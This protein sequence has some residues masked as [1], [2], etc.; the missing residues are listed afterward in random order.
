MSNKVSFTIRR[1]TPVSRDA[2]SGPESDSSGF[3]VPAIPRHL[4]QDSAPGSPLSRSRTSSPPA[5]PHDPDSS[6]DEG[7]GMQ[8]EL[9]TSFD[10]LNGAQRCVYSTSLPQGPLVIPAL[11]NRDW[12]EMARKRRSASQFVPDSAKA[13]TG[14]DGSVGGLGTR[15]TINSGPVL[16]GLQMR[17]KARDE[18]AEVDD[19]EV[20]MVDVKAQENE[21]EETEDQKALRA[22]LAAA[23][24][25][26]GEAPVIDVIKPV[27]ETD[28]FKQDVDELPDAAS[29]ED[30]DRVPVA[31][32]GLALLRG[33]GWKEGT[34]A[35]RKP[36][37]GLV[38]PYLPEARPALLGIGAKEQEVYDDGS[39]NKKSKRPERRYVPVIK[40]DKEANGSGR[41][42]NGSTT[43]S[44]RNSRSRSPSRRDDDRKRDSS[45]RDDYDDRK[46]ESGRRDDRDSSRR[47]DDRRRD[48][49][50][51]DRRREDRYDDRR[52][53][54]DKRDSDRYSSSS[55]R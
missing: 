26:V 45:R 40:Q 15:D 5:T 17:E 16:S 52:R 2:S 6:D 28:A 33:M 39:K 48:R 55:R 23:E 47:D 1:P 42:E 49:S 54:Y 14:K 20:E 32:F 4:T 9:V 19:Q 21:E 31:Q 8:D 34:A 50:Y 29:L 3:K 46:R 51:D 13:S 53:D 22:I 35:S 24:G 18:G 41:S 43:V 38:Q 11:K 10:A 7:D 36:G 37:K 25:M 12:R 27:S 30:Y 44:R